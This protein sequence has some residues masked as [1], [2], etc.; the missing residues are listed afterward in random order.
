MKARTESAKVL[1][2][3]NPERMRNVSTK[4]KKSLSKLPVGPSTVPHQVHDNAL[5]GTP[6]PGSLPGSFAVLEGVEG[7]EFAPLDLEAVGSDLIGF[8]EDLTT[9]Q[10]E[11]LMYTELPDVQLA[12]PQKEFQVTP[13]IDNSSYSDF[14]SRLDPECLRC[15]DLFQ[16]YCMFVSVASDSLKFYRSKFM[17]LA[18]KSEPILYAVSAWGG[19][20]HELRKRKG[21]FSR[22][23]MYM[24]KAAKLMCNLI[25]DNLKP[26]YKEDFIVLCAFYLIFISIKVCTGD[27]RMWRV[28]PPVLAVDQVSWWVGQGVGD[29]QLLQWHQ[30]AHFPFPVP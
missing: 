20:L 27:V 30:T 8:K 25:G 6:T 26:N 13:V 1:M 16:E 7:M 18:R 22:P 28:A 3:T 2:L 4:L 15:L 21:D 17:S 14:L 5:S 10:I 24:H 19:F 12:E 9:F 11:E 23:W 29:V